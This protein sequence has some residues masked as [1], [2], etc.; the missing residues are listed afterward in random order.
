MPKELEA[1][2][3]PGDGWDPESI[4]KVLEKRKSVKEYAIILHD[5][6]INENGELK[7]PHYHT[8]MNFG[9]TNWT[10]ED[11]AKW[12]PI[13]VEMVGRIKT[14][15][16]LTLRYY[17]NENE[18][19]KHL[20][21]IDDMVANFD[22][23]GYLDKQKQKA[24]LNKLLQQCADGTITQLN[25]TEYISGPVYA[26]NERKIQSAWKYASDKR[27]IAA[28]G[29]CQ[30]TIFW[31]WGDTMVGKGELCKMFA[32]NKGQPIYFTS[33]GKDPFGEYHGEPVAVLDDL[34]PGEPFSFAE[35]LKITDPNN[36]CSVHSRYHN[37]E[38]VSTLIFITS[39]LSPVEFVRQYYLVDEDGSQLYRRLSEVWHVT[40]ST[41]TISKYD[42]AQHTFIAAPPSPNPVPAYLATLTPAPPAINGDE[43]LAQLNQ[44][45]APTPSYTPEQQTLFSDDT[46]NM[47]EVLPF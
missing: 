34:R 38:L 20:Y 46:D 18:P 35:L 31:L 40:T 13:S 23:Q 47:K 3:Y 29:T 41:I 28:Q 16:A 17:L 44:T 22:V 15:K 9:N 39:P 45:Y 36:L 11:V 42:I 19:E 21:S 24:S 7:K 1:I 26:A 30:R 27:S 2:L 6:D 4:I 14:N 8:F 43:V 37:K 32:R 10:F 25:Y 12:F 33:T 5:K